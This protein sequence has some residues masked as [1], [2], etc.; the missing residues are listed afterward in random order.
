LM[1]L[2]VQ[3]L[4]PIFELVDFVDQHYNLRVEASVLFRQTL[5]ALSD[6]LDQILQRGDIG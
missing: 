4:L 5:A 1:V 6:G 3:V 2:V